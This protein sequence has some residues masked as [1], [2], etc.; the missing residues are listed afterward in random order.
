MKIS[1]PDYSELVLTGDLNWDWLNTVS[2]YF[3]IKL[4]DYLI[5][6]VLRS[7]SIY[8]LVRIKSIKETFEIWPNVPHKCSYSPHVTTTV[9]CNDHCVVAVIRNAKAPES[10]HRIVFKRTLK[11]FNEQSFHQDLSNYDWKKIGLI[12]DAELA[13]TV[14]MDGFMQNVNK[15]DKLK[16][17]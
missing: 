16:E 1:C 9:F 15:H 5:L 4:S 2:D 8:L 6:S 7:W 11:H 3:Q 10:Q 12:P 17:I 13:W 14:F